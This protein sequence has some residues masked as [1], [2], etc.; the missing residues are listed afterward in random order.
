[1]YKIIKKYL[2]CFFFLSFF[3]ISGLAVDKQE[4]PE[5]LIFHSLSCHECTKIKT[6]V[7]PV[8][9]KEFGGQ[10]T[11]VY[12]DTGELENYKL[13]LS[14]IKKSGSGFEFKVPAF[15]MKGKFLDNQNQIEVKLRNFIKDALSRPQSAQSLKPVD[16]IAHF[17]SFVPA[18]V[19][20]AGL[21][22]GINPCAFTV[23]VFFISFLALQSLL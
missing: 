13:F 9:Q 7:M 23:I 17:K 10:V 5:L 2:L 11:F 3:P 15:Y 21:E 22:D 16:P 14:L 1:M 12:L 8:I 18:S 4:M 6:Q 20:I 19:I